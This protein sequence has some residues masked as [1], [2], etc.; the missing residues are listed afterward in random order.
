MKSRLL[1]VAFAIA[2]INTSK[3]QENV[4]KLNPLG[5]I[6]GSLSVGYE[7]VLNDNHSAQVNINFITF[8]V[9]DNKF[10]GFGITPEYRFHFGNHENP[11]GFY[12]G[13]FIGFNTFKW[14][15]EDSYFDN[16]FNLITEDADVSVTSFSIGGIIGHQWIFGEAFALDL[17]LGA[18]YNMASFDTDDDDADPN[19]G[20][21]AS[22]ILPRLG[23]A[24]GYAF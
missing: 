2:F 5:L 23:L 21:A 16:N 13:P 3:A 17:N 24:I 9:G 20:L 12:A 11:K 10:S 15:Y 4:I 18:G 8:K 6:F 7:R 14:T 22:G 1:V 19:F